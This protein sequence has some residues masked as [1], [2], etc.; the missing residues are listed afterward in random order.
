MIASSPPTADH[1]ISSL[2]LDQFDTSVKREFVHF[3]PKESHRRLRVPTV[4]KILLFMVVMPEECEQF[5]LQLMIEYNWLL[6]W[7]EAAGLIDVSETP[8]AAVRLNT[9]PIQ[10]CFTISRIALILR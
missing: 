2:A 4:F 7:G 8:C 9:D 10:L 1:G 6:A 3:Y 5:R